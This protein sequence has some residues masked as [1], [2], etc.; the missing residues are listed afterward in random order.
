MTSPEYQVG[1]S[2]GIPW[3]R[4]PAKVLPQAL[5]PNR[6]EAREKHLPPRL[7]VHH[8][9]DPDAN[10][11]IREQAIG[12][13]RTGD[14]RAFILDTFAK[15]HVGDEIVAACYLASIL[16][17]SV[18]NSRGLHVCPTGDSGKGKSDSADAFLR[19][20]PDDAKM[21]GSITSKALFYHGIDPGRRSS[22]TTSP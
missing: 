11:P 9:P 19:L 13:L 14:P 22:S 8:G 4:S 1:S 16:S 3:C 21:Q 20:L 15:C 7:R 2:P 6:P 12:I 17:S 18:R 5:R 10:T